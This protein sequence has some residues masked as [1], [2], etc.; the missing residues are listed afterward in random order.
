[1]LLPML[2]IVHFC[3]LP[4]AQFM[5]SDQH[6]CFLQF[7]DFALS[8]YV[9]HI[10]SE[11]FFQMVQVA[12][13]ITGM[14]FVSILHMFCVS[15]VR[16]SCFRI[17]SSSFFITFL[18]PGTA[19]SNMLH[20]AVCLIMDYGI[21]FI[22]MDGSVCLHCCFHNISKYVYRHIVIISRKINCKTDEAT[23]II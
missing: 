1:M 7:L 12:P 18:S 23:N 22:V 3:I 8:R 13:V 14:A 19:R 20:V 21:R 2:N 10:F 5:C 11:Q 15:I 16:S 17:F 9:A 4:E 6:G